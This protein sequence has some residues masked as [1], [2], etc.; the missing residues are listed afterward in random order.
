MKI[1]DK[2]KYKK[3]KAM[4][5]AGVT[6]AIIAISVI[7]LILKKTSFLPSIIHP[8]TVPSLSP[9]TKHDA[10]DKHDDDDDDDDN[11]DD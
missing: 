4:V 9:D 5:L 2:N 11:D 8:T 6:T 3:V 7:A 1:E 10:G